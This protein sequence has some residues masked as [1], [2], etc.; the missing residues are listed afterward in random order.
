MLVLLGD[1]DGDQIIKSI[2]DLTFL[3]SALDNRPDVLALFVQIALQLDEELNPGLLDKTSS[4]QHS[5][6]NILQR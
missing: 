4:S 1:G 2:S 3:H 6:L 5:V